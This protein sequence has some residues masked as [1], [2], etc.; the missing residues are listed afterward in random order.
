MWNAWPII[1]L[2]ARWVL[3]VLLGQHDD[4]RGAGDRDDP[5]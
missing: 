3:L 2:T 4:T 1:R 5:T